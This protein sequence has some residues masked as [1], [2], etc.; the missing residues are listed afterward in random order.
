M[1]KLAQEMSAWK[2]VCSMDCLFKFVFR[3]NC[4][5]SVNSFILYKAFENYFSLFIAQWRKIKANICT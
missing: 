4:T 3:T 2:N 5:Y 1:L